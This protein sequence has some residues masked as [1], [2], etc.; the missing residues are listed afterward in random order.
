MQ[1]SKKRKMI[2]LF[3]SGAALVFSIGAY[4][5]KAHDSHDSAWEALFDGKT[6][7]GWTGNNGSKVGDAWQVIDGNLVLTAGGAGDLLTAETFAD[8]E[9][10]IEWKISKKGNSGILYRVAEGDEPVWASGMEYQVLDNIGYPELKNSDETAGSV[11]DIYAPTFEA[12]KPTGE[13]N[14]TR[15]RVENDQVEHW[16]N[17]EK[18]VSYNLKS[19]DWKARIANSKF[20]NYKQ[21]GQIQRGHIALQ[22][23]GDKVWYKNIK[24]IEL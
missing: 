16:L 24:I 5:T 21:F 18:V 1:S 10:Q 17:G 8:F 2:T 12:V 15:I 11:F 6:L 19:S 14:K 4:Q 9:L 3:T 20:S 22:D 7:T 13:F 23:H